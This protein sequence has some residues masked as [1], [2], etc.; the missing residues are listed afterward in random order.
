VYDG[1]A[2]DARGS[3]FLGVGREF[4]GDYVYADDVAKMTYQVSFAVSG[5]TAPYK[6]KI[7][8]IAGNIFTSGPVK[9]GEEIIVTITDSAGCEVAKNFKLS[10]EK[11]CELPCDGIALRCGHRFWLPEPVLEQKKIFK[12]YD[13]KVQ[14][15]KFEFPQGTTV[16]LTAEVNDII[17]ASADDLNR[18]FANT[19]ASWLKRIN[20]RIA[21]KTGS[22]DWL[23]LAYSKSLADSIGTLSI[24]HFACL[25]FEFRIVSSFKRPE[26]A[27]VLDMIYMPKVTKIQN[28]EMIIPAFNCIQIKKCDPNHPSLDLCKDLDL[29]LKI[30]KKLGTQN[31]TLSAVSSGKDKPTA[32]LWEVQDGIPGL[33]NEKV[34]TFTFKTRTPATKIIRLTAYTEN[35]CKVTTA[36]TIKLSR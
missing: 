21:Q 1:P 5:G 13:A 25:K 33:S 19:V 24:E 17:Q 18:N 12:S 8:T 36:D 6:T 10:V 16:D 27:E 26:E 7:G 3:G 34:A 28:L 32:Y 23:R 35:G 20:T 30:N 31:I 2:G 15:F 11:P 29:E 14:V 9:T 22:D 4:L